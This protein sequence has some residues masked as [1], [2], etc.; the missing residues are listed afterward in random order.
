M[1][2]TLHVYTI[3][4][5]PIFS[6][7]IENLI[8]TKIVPEAKIIRMENL[9]ALIN[10]DKLP[11]QN[12]AELLIYDVGKFNNKDFN[13]LLSLT[14]SDPDFKILIITANINISDVKLLF[15]IGVMGVVNNNILQEQ[16]IKFV[17]KILKGNKILSPEYWDLIIEYFFHSVENS[18][19]VKEKKNNT[20]EDVILFSE[21]TAREKE[22]LGYICDGKSTREISEELYISLHTVETHRRKILSKLGVKNTASMVKVA[23]KSNLVTI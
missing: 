23:I 16:F 18:D 7:G 13:Y 10:R 22:I 14:T 9:E 12:N 4:N 21:L 6:G 19:L 15:E 1:S 3:I 17:K 2:T 20:K 5:N 8:Q 11:S